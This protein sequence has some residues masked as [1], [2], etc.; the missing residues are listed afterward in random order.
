MEQA[1]RLQALEQQMQ[2]ANE[3]YIQAVDRASEPSFSFWFA[4][5][6]PILREPPSKNIRI[7]ENHVGQCRWSGRT[8][9]LI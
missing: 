8:R 3:E 7:S 4:D 6:L 9:P 1:I 5:S 2:D